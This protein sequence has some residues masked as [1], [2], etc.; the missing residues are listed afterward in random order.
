MSE[1][2][3]ELTECEIA[4]VSGGVVCG[5]A[6]IVGVAFAAGVVVGATIAVVKINAAK[7]KQM[8]QR[9]KSL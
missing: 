8:S 7:N 1:T 9:L 5:G 4:S 3:Y 2:T 6:C